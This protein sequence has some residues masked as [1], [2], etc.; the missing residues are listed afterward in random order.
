MRH[1]KLGIALV[2]GAVTLA[3]FWPVQSFEFLNY[4][5]PQYVLRNDVVREGLSAEGLRWAFTTTA[6]SNWHPL[7][8][9]SHMTDVQLFGLDPGMHHLSS[10]FLHTAGTILMFLALLAMTGRPWHSGAAAALFALHP[11]H[12]ESVAW[13]AE[14]KDLLSGVFWWACLVAYARYAAKPGT[15]RYLLTA[16]LFTAGLMAKPMVVTL[17]A[18]M[19]LLDFWPLRRFSSARR[20]A[21][22]V[23]EKVPFFLLA[24]LS[25]AVTWSAQQGAGSMRSL[26]VY[27]LDVRIG[28]ALHSCAAYLGKTL[29]PVSLAVFYPHPGALP[30]WKISL[31]ALLLAVISAAALWTVKSRPWFLTGWAWF[32]VTLLPVI[33]I[34]QVGWQ[35]M[36]DRYTYIPLAGIFIALVWGAAEIVPLRPAGRAAAALLALGVMISLG[37]TARQQLMTWR[38]STTLFEHALA[39]TVD[40]YVAHHNLAAALVASGRGTEAESH[41][42]E[43]IRLRPD[44]EKAYVSLG[45][46]LAGE[47]RS[48]EAAALF[49]AALG[50]VPDFAEAHYNLGVVLIRTGK[51]ENALEHLERAAKTRP[52]HWDTLNNLGALYLALDRPGEAEAPL[53]RSVQL[54]PESLAARRNLAALHARGGDFAQAAKEYEFILLRAPLSAAD[55][56]RL[57]EVL[58][59]LGRKGEAEEHFAEARRLVETGEQ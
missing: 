22:L 19:L 33:G 49:R 21:M 25:A 35:G 46:L 27:P 13:V 26:A 54:R 6:V 43:V 14:R 3:L 47:G 40:N 59:R 34:V 17:P 32:L 36:A 55:H 28:N 53:R 5:D 4:D 58:T 18:V 38:S 10:L 20:P 37:L 2:L 23:A 56:R 15:V 39:V 16:A 48:A 57:A 41:Y 9:I 24:L 1:R 31:A 52:N 8:W 11:L 29:L 7:T 51:Y 30:L 12:V 42:R 50:R 45:A 44:Y